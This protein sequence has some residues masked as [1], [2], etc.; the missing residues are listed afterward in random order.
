[1]PGELP[2]D[3]QILV[4]ALGGATSL[5]TGIILGLIEVYTG[6]AI[7]SWMFWFILPVG[8]FVSG[9]AAASGYY[10]GAVLFHQK[11][12]GGV[13]FNMVAASVTA[14]FI[15]HYI[16][17]FM[18]EVEGICVKDAISFWQYLDLDI[19]HTSLS[20]SFG[21]SQPPLSTGEL[22]SVF[23][24]V[25]A[26]LQLAG[27]SVG[28]YAVFCQ[29]LEHCAPSLTMENPRRRVIITPPPTDDNSQKPLYPGS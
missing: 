23:G 4:A 14:F 8:A 21:G 1:M 17:Y 5:L 24:Y 13:L 10:A 12:A 19:R 28:G 16:P 15:V 29:L 25:L 18:L 11:P 26:A 9:M 6:H 7:Y 20:L 2:T 22:G 3:K 27:F